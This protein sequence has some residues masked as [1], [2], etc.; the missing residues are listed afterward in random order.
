MDDKRIT[1]H[2]F[3]RL[4]VILLG[5]RA[6]ALVS[7]HDAVHLIEFNSVVGNPDP[8]R[9]QMCDAES[10]SLLAQTSAAVSKR[11]AVPLGTAAGRTDMML[12][13]AVYHCFGIAAQPPP[14]TLFK[15]GVCSQQI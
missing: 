7:I 14:H 13:A 2:I 11:C 6:V 12:S 3:Q 10:L 9:H 5:F 15:A 4:A 8:I 1:K